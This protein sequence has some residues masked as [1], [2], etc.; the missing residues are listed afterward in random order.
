MKEFLITGVSGQDGRLMA[1]ALIELGCRVTGTTRSQKKAEISKIARSHS[2]KVKVISLDPEKASD[3]QEL[4][5]Q[6][7]FD[8]IFHFS[9]QSSVGSSFQDTLENIVSPCFATY[10]MLEAIRDHSPNTKVILANSTEVFGSHGKL[11]VKEDT[12][13]KPESPYAVG[14]ANMEAIALFYRYAHGLWV[15]NVFLSNHESVYRSQ[16]FVTMKIVRGAHDISCK[17]KSI[18]K[19]GNLAVVRDWGWAP[20]Y[21]DAIIALMN[22]DAPRDIIIATGKSITLQNFAA[23]IFSFFNLSI[24]DYVETDSRLLR[25]SDPNEAY[26]CIKRA[27]DVL[28][29]NPKYKGVKVPRKLSSSYLR[30]IAENV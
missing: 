14:K 27:E 9:A 28:K 10:A 2:D 23:E 16:K 22:M 13:K 17:K 30:S 18:L 6:K 5:S 12:P 29:W 24:K 8:G 25:T 7:T 1:E 4:I 20:E 26:Y 11:K 19:L 3:W 15:S 21:I